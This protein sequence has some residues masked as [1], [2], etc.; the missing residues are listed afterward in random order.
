MLSAGSISEA[1]ILFQMP[2]FRPKTLD[3][4]ARNC[5]KCPQRF[6]HPCAAYLRGL[7]QTFEGLDHTEKYP[8]MGQ[9]VLNRNKTFRIK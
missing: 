7:P 1:L 8:K 5:S 9:I 6:F 4:R 3:L 2:Y